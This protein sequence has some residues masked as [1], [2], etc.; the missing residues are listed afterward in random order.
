ML[1]DWVMDIIQYHFI[2]ML[3]FFNLRSAILYYY[4]RHVLQS[5]DIVI[6]NKSLKIM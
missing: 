6:I 5:D 2:G 1:Q 3:K 4:A